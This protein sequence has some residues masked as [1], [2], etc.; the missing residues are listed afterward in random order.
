[1]V[2]EQ[3]QSILPHWN[4]EEGWETSS[5]LCGKKYRV[6]TMLHISRGLK[7]TTEKAKRLKG[8]GGGRFRMFKLGL[9]LVFRLYKDP[10]Q[11][12]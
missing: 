5:R 7:N 8:K 12:K 1:M 4:I 11:D 10:L 6:E 3:T 9:G 2:L